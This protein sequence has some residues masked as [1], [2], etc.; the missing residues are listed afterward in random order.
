MIDLLIRIVVETWALLLVVS[1]WL[2]IGMLI[3]GFIHAFIGE[4]FIKHHLG[5]SGFIPV[6]KSTLFGIPLPVCSCGVI[7]IA[8]GL[9]KDGASKASTMAFLVSTPTTGIDSIFVTYAFLGAVFTIARPL[10]ALIAGILVGVL[11][12]TFEK[13]EPTKISGHGSHPHLG[14]KERVRQG[15]YYGF[16][17]LPQDLGKTLLLGILIGGALTALLPT[18]IASTYLS[19]PLIAYP[20]MLAISVPLYVC[21]IGAVPIAAV[22][23]SKGLIAGA[24]L[25][26]L[27]AGPATNTITLAFVGKKIGKRVLLLYLTSIITSAVV[28][29]LLLDLFT[30]GTTM[31]Q[32]M[33]PGE[34]VPY[35]IQFAATILLLLVILLNSIKRKK[36]E[37]EMDHSFYVPDMTCKHCQ[38]TI[39]QALRKVSG[40]KKVEVHLNKKL[41][42]VDGDLDEEVI[43][44]EIENTGYSVK[45]QKMAQQQ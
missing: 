34:K 28:F 18:D 37:S 13:E 43:I 15:L 7:P 9:R 38:M 22:L 19:N 36:K 30:K 40:V 31:K 14:I 8:A 26:F 44:K 35:V 29:G 16:R 39:E 17:I 3:A 41:I 32:F 25:A 42:K 20:L 6:I 24:A 27:I 23:L 2:L 4:E 33:S 12:Y 1:P 11:V 10:A 45:K 5:G 21:A